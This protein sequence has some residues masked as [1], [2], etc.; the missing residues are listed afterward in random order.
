MKRI[1][2]E[3]VEP[4]DIILT[5]RPAKMSKLIRTSTGGS[6]SHAA[7]CVQNGSFVDSTSEGV[8]AHNFQRE[9]FEDSEE[10]F[11]LRLKKTLPPEVL[12]KIIE[13]AR[14]E[15]GTRYS[16]RQAISSVSPV[17]G[18]PRK[19]QFCSRLVAQA[20]S[21]G[22]IDLVANPD[23]CT[24]EDL[25][26]SDLLMKLSVEFENLS[27]EDLEWATA[28]SNPIQ[29]TQE[30]QNA[31]LAEARAISPN[32][33]T[34]DDLYDLLKSQKD[35]DRP[36]SDSLKNSG[37]LDLWRYDIENFP[38]RYTHGL[39]EELELPIDAVR[40]YC[41]QTLKHAYSGGIRFSKNLI[42]LQRFNKQHPRTSFELLIG[43][44]E[45]LVRNDQ[46]R[47]E[48][49]YEWLQ[50]HFPNQ[51]KECMEEIEPHSEYWYSI[52]DIVEPKLATISRHAILSEHRIDVC[53]SCGDYPAQSYRLVN[54]V[55]T[56]PGV[57]S[58]R[59]CDDCIDIRR[60]MGNQ[61]LPFLR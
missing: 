2:F 26:R 6:V 38:W 60:N 51:L 49:A 8:Q 10:V 36:I 30:A 44:Y 35:T 29:A 33:E 7:I 57:P 56:M 27:K 5:A 55:E 24:P 22:G 59:L 4:G 25:L 32:I 21:A 52:I 18:S 9:L 61:L 43:L 19:K 14:A 41:I 46:N 42:Q 1:R 15:I 40:D 48:V 23:Y 20:Y 37:Y 34:F 58:L 53:S 47:R 17:K 28:S 50:K 16:I 45:T 13:Y 54:G 39:I 31:V 3:S 11:H 12:A